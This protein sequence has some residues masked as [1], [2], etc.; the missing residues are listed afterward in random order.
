MLSCFFFEEKAFDE[1]I[2]KQ[3]FTESITSFIRSFFENIEYKELSYDDKEKQKTL[4]DLVQ[5]NGI[6]ATV[7]IGN[8]DEFWGEEDSG[9]LKK[10]T[11]NMQRIKYMREAV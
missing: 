5:S 6:N 8:R 1:Y 3:I 7:A 9:I 2:K 11:E 10:F 4:I